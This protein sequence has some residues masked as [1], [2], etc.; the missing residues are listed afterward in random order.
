L[1]ILPNKIR[2]K[3]PLNNQKSPFSAHSLQKPLGK[4]R[5]DIF[6][7]KLSSLTTAFRQTLRRY[8]VCALNRASRIATCFGAHHHFLLS[9]NEVKQIVETQLRCI[10]KNWGTV[11]DEAELLEN[12]RN[13]FL[14]RQFLN[15][16]VFTALEGTS[17][18]IAALADEL[19]KSI[20]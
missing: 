14:G 8:L 16:Y 9:Q 13:F 6:I 12:E 17:A 18:T 5:L 2:P 3:I 20:S 1:R 10:A 19:R 15:P 4:H 7:K 11:C